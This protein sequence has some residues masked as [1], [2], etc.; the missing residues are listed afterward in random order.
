MR[1]SS[2]ETWQ[3]HGR[4]M[5]QELN[6]TITNWWALSKALFRLAVITKQLAM[7]LLFLKW[8]VNNSWLW[9]YIFNSSFNIFWLPTHKFQ[10]P[11]FSWMCYVN[12]WLKFTLTL[13]YERAVYSIDFELKRMNSR[14]TSPTETSVIPNCK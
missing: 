13:T 7:A 6:V 12:L 3:I 8:F 4:E 5:L 11:S 9:F 1:G 14:V 10:G 2:S